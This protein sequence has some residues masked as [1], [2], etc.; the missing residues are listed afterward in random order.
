M[1]LYVPTPNILQQ[2]A[3]WKM[4]VA[5]FIQYVW[6]THTQ[7]VLRTVVAWTAQQKM[8]Q[9]QNLRQESAEF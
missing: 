9:M 8:L 7:E 4:H 5:G 3:L 6:T 1:L 2:L